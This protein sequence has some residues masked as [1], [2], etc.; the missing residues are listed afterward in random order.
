M[1]CVDW[2]VIKVQC[3]NK[4]KDNNDGMIDKHSKDKKRWWK[5]KREVW[6]NDNNYDNETNDN[7]D[8]NDTNDDNDDYIKDK[9]T[10]N[11][12]N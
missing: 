6:D 11:N 1:Q 12:N 3:N 9:S 2:T 10:N 7:N 8:N 4:V 5:I